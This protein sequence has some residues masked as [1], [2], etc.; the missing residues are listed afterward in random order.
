MEDPQARGNLNRLP[1]LRVSLEDVQLPDGRVIEGFSTIET[2]DVAVV[3][4]VTPDEL[5]LVEHSYKHGLGRV[6]LNLPAGY[7]NHGE[8]PL[9]AAQRELREETGYEGD[10]WISL[11]SFITDGNRGGGTNHLFLARNVHQVAEPDSGD[12][13]EIS[14]S[15]MPLKDLVRA[16]QAGEVGSVAIAAAVGMAAAIH[17]GATSQAETKTED[18]TA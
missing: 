1:W 16:T 14:L 3:V 11:G 6:C 17:W 5:V 7:I 9:V 4:A 13:E 15:L 12:L 2:P 8:I 10:D 18:I